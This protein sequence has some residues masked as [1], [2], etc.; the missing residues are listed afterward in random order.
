[1]SIRY[2]NTEAIRALGPENQCPWPTE[3][4]PHGEV[5]EISRRRGSLAVKGNK[6]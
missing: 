4:K 5:L 1:M 2:V 6:K 3:K